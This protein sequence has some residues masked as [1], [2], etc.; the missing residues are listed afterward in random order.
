MKLIS[1]FASIN[2]N[3]KHQF[4]KNTYVNLMTTFQVKTCS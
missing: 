2:I 4:C 1:I 3:N